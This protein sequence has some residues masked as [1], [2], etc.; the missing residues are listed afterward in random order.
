MGLGRISGSLPGQRTEIESVESQE[1]WAGQNFDGI[2]LQSSDIAILSSTTDTGNTDRT[3][4]LRGGNI[5]ARI[6]ATGLYTIYDPDKLAGTGEQTP[7]TVLKGAQDMLDDGVATT[8]FGPP[9]IRA[10]GLLNG[11]MIGLDPHARAILKQNGVLWD[12]EATSPAANGI[13]PVINL[14][15]TDIAETLTSAQNGSRFIA[16]DN[17]AA[18]VFTLPA[19]ENGL[20]FD[21]IQTT[22]QDMV[23]TSAETGNI[24]ALANAAADTVTLTDIGGW[25]RVTAMQLDF[26]GTSVLRWVY[27]N[28]GGTTFVV[29]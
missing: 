10:G 21:F 2:W 5:L 12:D 28:L 25:G 4:T 17:A 19:I 3:T 7:I 29:A 14:I 23:I 18:T 24:L 27:E 22:A 26:L 16:N 1:W 6:A 8:T 13:R 11:E 20:S 9:T 15:D